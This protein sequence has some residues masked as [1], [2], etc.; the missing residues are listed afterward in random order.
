V[1]ANQAS[2]SIAVLCSV[3]GLSRSGYYAWLGREPSARERQNEALLDV[4][5]E[6]HLASKGIY[7]SPRIHARFG[8]GESRQAGDESPD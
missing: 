8:V 5:R 1:K 6:E 2:H 4:I 7:G 3:L